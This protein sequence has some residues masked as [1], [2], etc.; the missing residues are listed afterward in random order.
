MVHFAEI[1]QA[2]PPLLS[3]TAY[4]K[5]SNTKACAKKLSQIIANNIDNRGRR[6]GLRIYARCC[7][8]K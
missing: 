6:I 1:K 3:A 8:K 7:L 5:S 4:W 2:P